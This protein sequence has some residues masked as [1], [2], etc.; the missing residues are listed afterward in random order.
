MPLVHV[1]AEAGNV[2]RR[3][4]AVIFV[5]PSFDWIATT[6]IQTQRKREGVSPCARK[7]SIDSQEKG[8]ESSVLFENL[9]LS[10]EQKQ[11]HFVRC[12]RIFFVEI[13]ATSSILVRE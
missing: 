5:C 1:S 4:S 10:P 11:H 13:T 12:K 3:H 7:L 9:L 2:V 8:T 6:A